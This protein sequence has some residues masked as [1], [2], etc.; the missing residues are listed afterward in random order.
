MRQSILCFVFL[1]TD[2]KTTRPTS[3][4]HIHLEDVLDHAFAKLSTAQDVP[5]ISDEERYQ[6][7][8]TLARLGDE[9]S[10]SFLDLAESRI[11][12]NCSVA[13][14][15]FFVHLR[16]IKTLTDIGSLESDM[17]LRR[18]KRALKTLLESFKEQSCNK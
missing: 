9:Y 17:K 16:T 18:I 11:Q 12:G 15:R 10:G 7:A 5:L 6:L 3:S 13:W 14:G 8:F 1:F 4:S 2:V